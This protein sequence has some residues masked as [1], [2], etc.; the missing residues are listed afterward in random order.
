[1][2]IGLLT[3]SVNPRGGVVHAL[4]LAQALHDAGHDVTVFAPAAPGQ[5]MFR[6]VAHRLALVPVET[7]PRD[8]HGMVASRIAAFEQHLR[9]V[10]DRDAFHLW[11]AHDG[12][13]GSALANLVDAGLVGGFVRTVHHLDDF[14]DA[15]VM[16]WQRRSVARAECVLCVSALWCRILR[17]QHGVEAA[18]VGNG[19][20]LRRYQPQPQ[21]GDAQVAQRLGLRRGAPLWLCVG[22]VEERKNT[23]RALQA[24]TLH[25]RIEP[26]AQLVIAGGASLLDHDAYQQRFRTA[27]QSSGIADA[28]VLTGTVADADMPALFCLADGLLM[29]SLR[30]GFGLVVLEALASRT[31]VVVPRQAPFTEYLSDDDAQW[32]DPLDAHS[33]AAAMQRALRR[34]LQAVPDVCRRFS[35]SASAQRHL[36]IYGA[37]RAIA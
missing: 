23:L 14:D 31:P 5:A 12:L 19:V 33:I 35:W 30:E 13:G 24:F 25:K 32:C 8:L 16:Q 7:T 9:A 26:H 6:A 27:L 4:E 34:P 15:R 22:G 10:P 18:L 29:P 3:H 17:Q 1:M 37:L 21:A 28:V 2:K 36:E 20:D 11:H